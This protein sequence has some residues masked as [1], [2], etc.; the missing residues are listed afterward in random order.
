MR[1][2]IVWGVLVLTLISCSRAPSQAEIADA[3]NTAI[4]ATAQ[5]QPTA[6]PTPD[7]CA[8]DALKAYGATVKPMLDA[9]FVQLEIT[10]S[11]PRISLGPTLQGLLTAEQAVNAVTPPP[12]LADWFGRTKNMMELYRTSMNQFAA[13]NES[14]STVNMAQATKLREVIEPALGEIVAGKVPALP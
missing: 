9:Y 10:Q 14:D 11:T 1:R 3:A 2:W 4:A 13:Q 8:P 12:C 5:A 7:P 6:V